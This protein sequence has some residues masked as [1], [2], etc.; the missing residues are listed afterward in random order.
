[1]YRLFIRYS[2]RLL[3]RLTALALLCVTLPGCLVLGE[4]G[5]LIG[6]TAKGE[7]KEAASPVSTTT[8][9]FDGGA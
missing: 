6:K 8:K 4:G 7:P 1:M 5:G 2:R 9:F 3:S